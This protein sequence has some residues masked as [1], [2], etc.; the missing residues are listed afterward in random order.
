[1]QQVLIATM[2]DATMNINDRFLIKKEGFR[3]N[4]F[5][6]ESRT[7]DLLC[8]TELTKANYWPTICDLIAQKLFTSIPNPNYVKPIPRY[9]PENYHP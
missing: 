8:M 7:S 6:V 5:H 9:Y 2:K 1:M 4:I 3:M